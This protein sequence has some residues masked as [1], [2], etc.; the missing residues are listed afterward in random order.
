MI[1]V[2]KKSDKL[3]AKRQ[4]FA[5]SI[6]KF[7]CVQIVIVLLFFEA[8]FSNFDIENAEKI[9]ESV[10]VENTEGRHDLF[11][12]Y[13]F[14]VYSEDKEYRFPNLGNNRYFME[15]VATDSIIQIT[16]IEK[17]NIWGKNNYV[18]DARSETEVYLAYEDYIEQKEKSFVAFVVIFAVL[19]FIFLV[20]FILYLIIRNWEEDIS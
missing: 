10:F 1:S 19:E 5:K 6:I 15:S 16:Y 12:D 3:K 4:V 7:V 8:F 18:I 11:G 17:F 20:V 13:T 9:T 14:I 2:A